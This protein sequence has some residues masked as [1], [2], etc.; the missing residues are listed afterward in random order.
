AGFSFGGFSAAFADAPE[1][2]SGAR[3]TTAGS[4]AGSVA[5]SRVA[6]RPL[7]RTSASR[8]LRASELKLPLGYLSRYAR[9]SSGRLD[10]R[11]LIQNS[12]SIPSVVSALGPAA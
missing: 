11:T 1:A 5:A 2:G 4:A 10:S 7:G 12:R 6:A 9:M 8:R 3:A